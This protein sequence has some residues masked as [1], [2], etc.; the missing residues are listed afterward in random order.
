ML[1]GLQLPLAH[2]RP[3]IE[4]SEPSSILWVANEMGL[5]T[6]LTR[7]TAATTVCELMWVTDWAK[8]RA[9]WQTRESGWG[10]LWQVSL[11]NLQF[12]H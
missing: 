2:V 11:G 9:G 8:P 1:P 5:G 7:L 3:D 10:C 6:E 12:H 4:G